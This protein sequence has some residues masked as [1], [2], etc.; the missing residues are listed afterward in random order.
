VMHSIAENQRDFFMAILEQAADDRYNRSPDIRQDARD[1][2]GDHSDN[3]AL[4][5]YLRLLREVDD[6]VLPGVKRILEL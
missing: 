2:L 3:G 1:F 4:M 6:G 5:M